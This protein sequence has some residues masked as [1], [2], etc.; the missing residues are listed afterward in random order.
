LFSRFLAEPGAFDFKQGTTSGNRFWNFVRD[1]IAKPNKELMECHE[2]KPI[3]L[4]T[5]L[6]NFPYQ[7][8][9]TIVPTQMLRIGSVLIAGVPG[10]F[11]TMSGRRLKTMLGKEANKVIENYSDELEISPDLKSLQGKTKVVLAGLSNAYSS[12]VTTFEEYQVQRY[13]GASTIFGPHTLEAYLN[14]YLNLTRKLVSG[15]RVD[16]LPVGPEPP[17]LLKKQLSFRPGVIFDNP[18]WKHKFGDVLLQPDEIYQP[19]MSA[20]AIFVAGHPQNNLMLEGT[21]L[22]VEQ[23]V[24]GKDE[25][26]VIATDSSLETRFLW[27]R[28]NSILGQSTAR[29]E[30]N[31]PED[32]TPGDYRLRHFGASKYL[33]NQTISN[34]NGTTKAFKVVHKNTP[35][36]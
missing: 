22:T 29:I 35:L 15:T 26:K 6:M 18:A 36:H 17:F 30:W 10:E 1:F 31:I 34:Y 20:V 14:Q 16:P 8:Q 19:G 11:S 5:G 33:F 25:W 13:E 27:R 24:H 7:W 9:P 28:T 23:R 3:L 2:P 32:V 12:Y 4:A 21:Y